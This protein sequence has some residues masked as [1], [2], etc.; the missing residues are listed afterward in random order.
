MQFCSSAVQMVGRLFGIV[1]TAPD[2][3][4]IPFTGISAFAGMAALAV[5]TAVL[6]S[7]LASA[8]AVA[9]ALAF[10]A[11][12][13]SSLSSFCSSKRI[14]CYKTAISASLLADCAVAGDAAKDAVKAPAQSAAVVIIGFIKPSLLSQ[15]SRPISSDRSLFDCLLWPSPGRRQR[16]SRSTARQLLESSGQSRHWRWRAGAARS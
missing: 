7:V 15:Y 10:A 16:W 12:C 6:A 1:T 13:F 4:T 14:C 5:V 9:A 8:L 3:A 11:L 2:G